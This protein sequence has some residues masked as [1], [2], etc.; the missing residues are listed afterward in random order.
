MTIINHRPA[1]RG[2]DTLGKEF[3]ETELREALIELK[4]VVVPM[5]D[6]PY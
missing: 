2:S 3:A 4:K 1:M 6:C 5:G